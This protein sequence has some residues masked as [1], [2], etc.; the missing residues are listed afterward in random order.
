MGCA[1]RRQL[2]EPGAAG[3]GCVASMMDE[4][5]DIQEYVRVS[6]YYRLKGLVFV[7]GSRKTSV[8]IQSRKGRPYVRKKT[9]NTWVV[10]KSRE[11]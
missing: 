6:R 11:L 2:R 4:V 1:L 10:L 9:K 3:C 7:E 8:S 5:T